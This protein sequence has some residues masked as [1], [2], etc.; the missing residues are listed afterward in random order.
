MTKQRVI[1]YREPHPMQDN[2]SFDEYLNK[3]I[4]GGEHIDSVI[5]LDLS[6]QQKPSVYS[7]TIVVS[8]EE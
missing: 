3:L 7:A 2:K 8:S 6:C 4:A 5:V 1:Q